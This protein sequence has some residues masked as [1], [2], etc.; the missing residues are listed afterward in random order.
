MIVKVFTATKAQDRETLGERATEWIAANKVEV[1]QC[2]VRQSSD[3]AFH[4]LSIILLCKR[5]P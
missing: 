3:S 1:V 2:E 5:K 4:C